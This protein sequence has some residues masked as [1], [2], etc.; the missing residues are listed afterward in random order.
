MFKDTQSFKKH[1]YCTSNATQTFSN[2][3]VAFCTTPQQ[4]ERQLVDDLTG[5]SI[6]VL[7]VIIIVAGVVAGLL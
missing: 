2:G 3:Y 7:Y 4:K 5:D 1:R 6:P